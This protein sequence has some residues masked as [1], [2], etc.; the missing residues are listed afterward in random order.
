MNSAGLRFTSGPEMKGLLWIRGLD[1]AITRFVA[2][3][4]VTKQHI[5]QHALNEELAVSQDKPLQYLRS[6][7]C[8]EI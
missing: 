1:W 3:L 6:F 7:I 2:S 5:L 8:Q 4:E